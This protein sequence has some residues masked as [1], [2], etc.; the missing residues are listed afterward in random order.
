MRPPSL[1][2]P[3]ERVDAPEFFHPSSFINLE[4]CALSVLGAN[5]SADSLLPVG[6]AALLGSLIH[7]V[8][9]QLLLGRWGDERDGA[10]AA[11]LVLDASTGHFK[12]ALGT[13]AD[14][15]PTIKSLVGRRRW[16]EAVRELRT[17]ATGLN[18][19]SNGEKPRPPA[20][21]SA[22][23]RPPAL[24]DQFEVGVERRVVSNRLRI[25]GRPDKSQR[26]AALL[27]IADFKSG[28]IEDADGEIRTE[29]L[30]QL[31]LYAL[32]AE[33]AGETN[34]ALYVE[35]TKRHQ[36]PWGAPQ[37]KMIQDRLLA[38]NE[39]L[40]RGATIAAERIAT[41]GPH[42][43]FCRV[44][45]RCGQYLRVAPSWWRDGEGHPRPLPLD[46]WGRLSEVRSDGDADHLKLQAPVHGAVSVEGIAL[47]RGLRHL[48]PGDTLWFF[49]LEATE[50]LNQ[51]GAL[52][53][54]RNMHEHPPGPRWRRAWQVSVYAGQ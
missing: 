43:R 5:H 50:D 48:D 39:L 14:S 45:H 12:A 42:C 19:H 53:H 7:H 41:P 24:P 18:I 36:V 10:A 2:A 17:W 13:D 20:L 9:H 21:P 27:E 46:A 15:P 6:G 22:G 37:R 26:N 23:G 49:G 47:W 44:R 29:Y 1:P 40:P 3:I 35:D 51:H 30:T 8:R 32:V 54:P 4:R 52:V 28:N 33:D 11:N 25:A 38:A 31:H 34:L 16:N